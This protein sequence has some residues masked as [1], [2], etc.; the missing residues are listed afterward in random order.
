[1]SLLRLADAGETDAQ[2]SHQG[3]NDL[4]GA[5]CR[6]TSAARLAWPEC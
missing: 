1:M 4:A 5:A 2:A 6:E 3:K